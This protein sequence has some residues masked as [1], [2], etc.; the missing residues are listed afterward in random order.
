MVR[1]FV[2]P[3][4]NIFLHFQFFDEV[5][6]SAHLGVDT[7]T[8]VLTQAVLSELDEKKWSGTRREKARAQKLLKRLDALDL[9]TTPVGLR[10]GVSVMALDSEPE[11]EL[12]AQH[13][14]SA[15]IVDDRLVAAVLEFKNAVNDRV[16]ILSDDTG[17]RIKAK[18]RRLDVLDPPE[19]L[20]SEEEPDETERELAK[21][22]RELAEARSAVPEL[23][24]SFEAGGDHI[25]LDWRPVADFDPAELSQLLREWRERHPRVSGQGDVRLPNGT[26][27]SASLFAGVQGYRSA[28]DAAT[29]NAQIERVFAEYE[30]YLRAWPETLNAFGRTIQFQLVLENDGTGPAED[31]DV[32]L[33]T[34][35]PG[36]WHEER[37]E[38]ASPPAVP[39]ERGRFD[40][41]YSDVLR[42]KMPD[43]HLPDLRRY[44]EPID[45]PNISNDDDSPA[46]VHW[47]VKRAKHLVPVAL[48]AVYFQF[49]STAEVSSFNVKVRLLAANMRK[50]RT[51]SL[52]VEIVV[53]ERRKPPS[54]HM[55]ND[56]APEED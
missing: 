26:V 9:S 47:T 45:G 29:R 30:A 16:V 43:I 4:T 27:I 20:R 39:R 35:A 24:L 10:Q 36:A 23:R 32:R 6:W 49:N 46:E 5:D 44:D 54:P 31:V 51:S 19:S 3:D 33:T 52:H 56:A 28:E 37:P 40:F 25:Q 41:L 8:L 22:K 21:T 7:V 50:P 14:L 11:N 1:A 55:V 17:L 13:R 48:P 15:Q 34:D 12:F 2:F 53:G 18:G 38:V 42:P